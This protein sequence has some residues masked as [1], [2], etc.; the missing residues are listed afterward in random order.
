MANRELLDGLNHAL[1][2]EVGTMLRYVLQ[3]ASIKGAEWESVRAMYESEVPDELGHAQYLANKIAM[4]G[5]TPKLSPDLSSPPTDPR[6]MLR[7]DV[8][9]ERADVRH[10][11]KL[12]ELADK[13]DLIELKLR[14]EDQAADE[15]KHAEEMLRLLG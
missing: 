13:E 8:E 10:Y 6:E 12:A 2:R 7:R 5:G 4:L 11:L 1:N 9:E 15:A 3:A 14:M